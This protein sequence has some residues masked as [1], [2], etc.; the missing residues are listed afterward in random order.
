[1]R[2][3]L[4]MRYLVVDVS[5]T[6]TSSLQMLQLPLMGY[7]LQQWK[8]SNVFLNALLSYTLNILAIS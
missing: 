8:S 1:M 2:L 3:L 6:P 7:S 4:F 5:I